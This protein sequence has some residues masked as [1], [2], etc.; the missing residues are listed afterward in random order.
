MQVCIPDRLYFR[1]RD[2]AKI[3]EVK[4]Y[5]LRYW[6]SEFSVIQPKKSSSGHR[7]YRRS[8]VEMLAL[9]RHLLYEE[10]YSL[11]GAKKRLAEL[12]KEGTLKKL[13]VQVLASS[14]EFLETEEISECS[15]NQEALLARAAQQRV[16][17]SPSEQIKHLAEDLKQILKVSLSDLFSN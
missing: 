8:D 2:V 14:E 9:V 7:V 10:R 1:I 13:K 4:P 16:G 15:Q 12:R 11:E 5:V 17:D 3:L 6:E